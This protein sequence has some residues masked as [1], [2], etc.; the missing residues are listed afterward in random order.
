MQRFVS[1]SLALLIAAAAFVSVAAQAPALAG[2]SP[3]R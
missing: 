2:A 1:S 3:A